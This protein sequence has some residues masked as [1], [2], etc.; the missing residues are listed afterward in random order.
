MDSYKSARSYGTVASYRTASNGR[1]GKADEAEE[2]EEVQHEN[3]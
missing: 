1:G 3:T 2:A